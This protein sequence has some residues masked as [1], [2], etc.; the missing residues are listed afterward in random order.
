M[1]NIADSGSYTAGGGFS[2]RFPRPAWQKQ[3]VS[4]YLQS[5]VGKSLVAGFNASN[6]AYPDLTFAS[7]NFEVVIG[8]SLYPMIGGTSAAAPSLAGLFS[9]VNARR[10]A[11][12]K[13]GVGFVNPTLYAAGSQ[14]CC[15]DITQGANMCSQQDPQSPCMSRCN[16]TTYAAYTEC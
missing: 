2:E 15:N 13:G 9:L 5:N 16:V 6:R 10:K 1:G 4:G 12:G 7:N 14:G 11:Q 3:A 8:G